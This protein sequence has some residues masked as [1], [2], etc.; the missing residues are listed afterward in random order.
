[1]SDKSALGEVRKE[2]YLMF[3]AVFEDDLLR[4]LPKKERDK[5]LGK[6]PLIRGRVTQDLRGKGN[7]ATKM[8]AKTT[9]GIKNLFRTTAQQRTLFADER[10]ELIDSLPIYYTGSTR[11]DAA[12]TAIDEQIA[13]LKQKRVDEKILYDP[14]KKQLAE[15]Q[16]K[17]LEIERKPSKG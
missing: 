13:E 5:M 1:M 15:L 6:V 17:R 4:K 3:K 11:D 10:G 16:G 14:Y 8:F 12:L 9:R 2:F 7:I